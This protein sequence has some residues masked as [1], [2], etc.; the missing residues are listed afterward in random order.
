[1]PVDRDARNELAESLGLL[2]NGQMTNDEFDGRYYEEWRKC[3]D[4]TVREIAGFGYSLYSESIKRSIK[5]GRESFWRRT[6]IRRVRSLPAGVD[7]WTVTRPEA[8]V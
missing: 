4:E 3:E 7:A 5:R 6:S 1:M 2:V 8:A